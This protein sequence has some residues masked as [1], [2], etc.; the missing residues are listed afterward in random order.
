MKLVRLF[1]W[2]VVLLIGVLM[3][4]RFIGMGPNTASGPGGP[5]TLT[6]H[7]GEKV[8]DTDFRGRYMLIYFG[9]SYCPDVCPLELH[10]M[11]TALDILE[12][13]GYDI[14]PL[15]PIFITVDPER[16]TVPELADYV[17]DFHPSLVALT[18]TP[19]EIATVAKTFRVY[20]KKRVQEGVSGYL[21]DH[22]SY[23]L[24]MDK[25]GK[26]NRLFT[27]KDTPQDMAD[28]FKPVLEKVTS[29]DK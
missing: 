23:I 20:Y 2:I 12:D 9:Y 13:E 15:Q 22:Q 1:A 28:T 27:G 6:A 29:D 5:F 10:K 18:G 19:Q 21:M 8:S 25:D 3:A 24:V 17:Q 4:Y 26:Y 11:S 14:T 16:D 7:T